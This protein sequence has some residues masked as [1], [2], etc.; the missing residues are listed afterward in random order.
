MYRKSRD[1]PRVVE[2]SISIEGVTFRFID[3]AG[4]RDSSDSVEAMGIERTHEQIKKAR[5][6]LYLFDIRTTDCD[7][8]QKAAR[9]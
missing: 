8:I 7:E 5:I 9:V 6:I 4:L 2:D 3:T 1:N